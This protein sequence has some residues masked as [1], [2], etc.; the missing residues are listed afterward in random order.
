MSWKPLYE[1]TAPQSC[2]RVNWY[3][4]QGKELRVAKK[5]RVGR[6]PKAFRQMAVARMKSCES[7]AALAKELEVHRVLLYKWRDQLEPV[8]EE[9]VPPETSREPKLRQEIGRLKRLLADKTVEVDFFKGALQKV[10]ARRQS[11][12][13]SGGKAST[14]R[15]GK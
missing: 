1:W 7:I 3:T 5:K 6:Y 9:E 15:Y 4:L 13:N 11:S 8:D 12:G 2:D 10:E 14:T